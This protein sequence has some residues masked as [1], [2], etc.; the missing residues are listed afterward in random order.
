VSAQASGARSYLAFLSPCKSQRFHV[1]QDLVL[2]S[3]RQPGLSA[4]TG[5]VS[6]R[7]IR[8]EDREALAICTQRLDADAAPGQL[9]ANIL[10]AAVCLAAN[11]KRHRRRT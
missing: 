1:I 2:N 9:K 5:S 3:V 4:G 10:D 6:P 7:P 11:A 8:T